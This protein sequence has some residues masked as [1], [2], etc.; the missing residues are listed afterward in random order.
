M[1]ILVAYATIEGQ[2]GKIASRIAEKVEAAAKLASAKPHPLITGF[3]MAGD[4][5]IGHPSDFTRAFDIARDGELG[6]TCHAGEFGGA[7]SVEAALDYLKPDRIGHGV[8]A[9]E[10]PALVRRLAESGTVLEV[11][12]VSNLVLGVFPS[13]EAHPLRQLVDAGC[14]VT[15]NSDDPP[16]FHTTL[17][18]EYAVASEAFGFDDTALAGFTRTAIEAAFVD[19]DTRARLLEK[20]AAGGI[21]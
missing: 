7:D 18:N 15:L 6:I 12:P 17:E 21:E 1:I 19:G 2:T 8:R 4:E 9:I 16:H 10:H 5:R 11:C 3:G 13:V 14:K 20:C